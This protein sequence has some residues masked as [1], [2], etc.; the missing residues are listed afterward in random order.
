MKNV[1]HTCIFVVLATGSVVAA[2]LTNDIGETDSYQNRRDI[3]KQNEGQPVFEGFTAERAVEMKITTYDD[4]TARIKSFSVKRDG[5]GQW[6]IP[7][8]NNYPADA[9]EQMASA[10][11][12]FGTLEVKE[13][14]DVDSSV[15]EE[16]RVI[17]PNTE[18]LDVGTDGVGTLITVTDDDGKTY[19]LIVGAKV[20]RGTQTGTDPRMQQ[21]Y[22]A[23]RKLESDT[24]FT[25]DLNLD[26]FDTEFSKWI[27]TNLLG[28]NGL[29]VRQ[30]TIQD[31][32]ISLNPEGSPIMLRRSNSSLVLDETDLIWKLDNMVQYDQNSQEPFTIELTENEELNG[33]RINMLQSALENLTIHGVMRKPAILRPDLKIT[34][35][36]IANEKTSATLTQLGL[37]G[38]PNTTIDN[39]M[40]LKSANGEIHISLQTGIKYI[41]RFGE[42]DATSGADESLRR[43]LFVTT[44]FQPNMIP[45]PE[46]KS[47][48]EATP[49]KSS[50][51][52]DGQSDTQADDTQTDA[53][54]DQPDLT[55][56]QLAELRESI[57]RENARL[58]EDY[59]SKLA[60]AQNDVR[61]LNSRFAN[62]FYLIDEIT[63]NRIHLANTDLI[64]AKSNELGDGIP[65]SGL[66][67]L[68]KLPGL[69]D[70]PSLP[71]AP[72]SNPP[73]PA[74]ENE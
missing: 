40:D 23:A 55:P 47:L 12:A 18:T 36:A 32:F 11:A 67:G 4:A 53:E 48:P 41:L 38:D 65:D 35:E 3:A 17:E 24:V 33:D 51:E 57:E 21:A 28:L 68:P 52:S 72:K 16:Y 64:S 1:I 10:A 66:P 58:K 61:L 7:S 54:A 71:D 5:T 9:E 73:T 50:P 8:H 37:F 43:Y 20:M 34:P 25:I 60:K 13:V 49:S 45:A 74:P 39:L 30:L 46:Y 59:E 19:S 63:Y 31:Y 70:A 27:D 2:I 69:P 44:T 15:H 56:E 6:V 14:V 42:I 22:Y 26:V 29:D 62:W